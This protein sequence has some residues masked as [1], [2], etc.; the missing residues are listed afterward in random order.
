[1]TKAELK[2]ALHDA[3]RNFLRQRVENLEIALRSAKESGNDETKSTTGDKHETGK[4]MMQLEQEKIGFQL[5]ELVKLNKVLEGIPTEISEEKIIPGNVVITDH[6]KFYICISAG[7]LNLD[8]EEF[9]VISAISPL[10]V[11]F[12]RSKKGADVIVQGKTYRIID[13]F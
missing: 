10:G 6:G 12:L 4:A 9:F 8:K 3:S 13:S 2:R 1:M 5:N 11:A 7:K